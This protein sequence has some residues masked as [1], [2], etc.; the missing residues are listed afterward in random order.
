M[1][2]RRTDPD[3]LD[4]MIAEGERRAPGFAAMV[5]EAYERRQLTRGLAARRKQLNLSQTQVAARMRTA[6]SV[7]SK[8]ENGGDF[9]FS[10]L[11][12][13]LEVLGLD[14]DYE[15]VPTRRAAR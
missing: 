3:F 15:F 7:V 8:L 11:Q 12:K 5:D 4:E 14:M 1:E 9:K 6:A 10:T 13:Y 2:K